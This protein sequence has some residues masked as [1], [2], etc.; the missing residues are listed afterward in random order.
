MAQ[1]FYSDIQNLL[2][3]PD[4]WRLRKPPTPLNFDGIKN[5]N[6][7]FKSAIVTAEN[8]SSSFKTES[9]PSAFKAV[10]GL[11]DQKSLTVL[12]NLNMF[13]ARQDAK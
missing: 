1:V 8:S 13:V 11:K 7:M 10:S 2:S 9:G 5:D 12:D 4:M 3:M 6:T